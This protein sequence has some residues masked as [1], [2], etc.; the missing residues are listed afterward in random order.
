VVYEGDDLAEFVI[1]ANSARQHMST[2]ARAMSTALVLAED[3]D[4]EMGAGS[5]G[6]SALR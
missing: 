4:G 5:A 1:D 6:P 3:A 2:G